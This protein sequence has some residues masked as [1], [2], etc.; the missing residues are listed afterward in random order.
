M[1]KVIIKGNIST[2]IELS[3]TQSG[4][5]YTYFNVAVERYVGK[6]KDK[7]TDFIPCKAWRQ[8]AVFINNYFKKG[9]Q[10]LIDGNI[11]ID[12][13]EKDGAKKTYTYINVNQ[14]EFCG[15]KSDGQDSTPQQSQQSFNVDGLGS[16]ED[17]DANQ[18]DLP[19]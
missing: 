15:K 18:S 5:E 13:Y 6:D 1:N 2:D 12:T 3:T 8:T 19:F 17:I 9:Q 11:Q 4:I 14:V 7:Q 16:F 10:I